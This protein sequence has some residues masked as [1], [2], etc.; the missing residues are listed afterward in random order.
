MEAGVFVSHDNGGGRGGLEF[1]LNRCENGSLNSLAQKANDLFCVETLLQSPLVREL[2][3]VAL[4]KIGG[5][6]GI[7]KIFQHTDQ[8]NLISGSSGFNGVGLHGSRGVN[9]VIPGR[10]NAE[11]N[12]PPRSIISMDGISS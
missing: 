8:I 5:V 2:D 7:E 11:H 10:S 3:S 6:A 9:V 1:L 12:T 4:L